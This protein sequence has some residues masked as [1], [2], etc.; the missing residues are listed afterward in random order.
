MSKRILIRA[1]S[2][3]AVGL[4]HITRCL[5]L[6]KELAAKDCQVEFL[7]R[8]LPDNAAWLPERSGFT[9]HRLPA[10]PVDNP[11]AAATWQDDAKATA[12]I[13]LAGARPICLIVDNYGLDYR[14]ERELHSLVGRLMV[15]DDLADRYHE[16]DILLD[17]NY[18]DNM[19]SRYR[20]LVPDDCRLFLGLQYALLRPE[21]RVMLGCQRP[22][23]GVIRRILI[24]FG[25]SDP[26]NETWKALQAL[27]S[28]PGHSLAVDV[29]IGAAH[30]Q[31]NEIERL[32]ATRPGTHFHCQIDYMAELMGNADLAIGAG[33]TAIWERCAAGLPTVIIAVAVNQIP[34]AA[35][36]ARVGAAVYLGTS[37][38]VTAE[39]IF[40]AVC[41]LNN[42]P[43]KVKEMAAR[44]WT[45]MGF[46]HDGINK[47]VTCIVEE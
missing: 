32:C 23:D 45:L 22:R 30:R 25:G 5:T 46:G 2:S 37:D 4:G 11:S 47:L 14:W 43:E 34:S 8:D 19:E 17:Q 1:D 41:E 7:C 31:R 39:D 16:C 20:G 35:G 33:G 36:V 42:Q 18:C 24:F 28:W 44:A 9:V 13:A 3:H 40:A 6:A 27:H 29:V 38:R 15:I 21:F 26:T 12:D 10:M